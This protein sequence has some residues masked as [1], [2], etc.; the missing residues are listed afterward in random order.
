MLTTVMSIVGTMAAI[1]GTVCFFTPSV[2]V[3]VVYI[4]AGVTILDSITQVLWGD[5][6][7]LATEILTYF[8]GAITAVVFKLNFWP[9]VAVSFCIAAV[10]FTVLEL[11]GTINALISY[12]RNMKEERAEKVKTIF[13]AVPSRQ[14]EEEYAKYLSEQSPLSP[15]EA[16]ELT[17]IIVGSDINDKEATMQRFDEYANWIIET[18]VAGNALYKIGFASATLFPNDVLT[19]EESNELS[20]KYFTIL[21]EKAKKEAETPPQFPSIYDEHIRINYKK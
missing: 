2:S 4:C 7:N 9:T 14:E 8:I 11:P 16:R 13:E 1:T 15:V 20:K 19:E 5:Q 18:N 6:N 3:I 12:R 21:S 10:I 17:R